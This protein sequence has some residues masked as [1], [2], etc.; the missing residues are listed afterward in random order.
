MGAKNG[1]RMQELI[2]ERRRI[3]SREQLLA[4]GW[5]DRAIKHAV[6]SGRLYPQW[7]GIY[8]VGTPQLSQLE[9]WMAAVL[10]CGPG[11]A[12]SHGTGAT[13]F[14]MR[15]RAPRLVHVSVP[16]S[17]HP[18]AKGIVVHRRAAF[19]VTEFR[20]IAVT[21]PTCTIVDIAP[22]LSTSELEGTINRADML[23]LVTVP[24]LRA[25]LEEMPDRP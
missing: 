8:A 13:I 6:A 25:A 4:R 19:E 24:E 14:G 1:Q 18:R 20:G 2:D 16:A 15:V 21:T 17:R 22:P 5:T 23:G 12:A 7:P 11:A 10:A 9:A 3:V